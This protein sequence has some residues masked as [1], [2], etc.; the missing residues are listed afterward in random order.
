MKED[1]ELA[2]WF[3]LSSGILHKFME[4]FEDQTRRLCETT[5]KVQQEGEGLGE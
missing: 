4:V 5:G 3:L 1:A 2:P